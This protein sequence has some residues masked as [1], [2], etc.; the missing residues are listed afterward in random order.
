MVRASAIH[1]L[2]FCIKTFTSK[3]VCSFVFAE[4]NI[5]GIIDFLQDLLDDLDVN[6]VCRA[7]EIVIFYVEF[8][9]QRF[10]QLTDLFR[11]DKWTQALILGRSD[12]LVAMFIR[13]RKKVGLLAA[14][15]VESIK[16]IGHNR[17]VS[18]T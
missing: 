1:Q 16:D 13:S 10:E 6:G 11:I 5:S 17:R 9:P 14:H 2:A 8:R 12:H 15:P 4:V 3:T 18:M 7:Y